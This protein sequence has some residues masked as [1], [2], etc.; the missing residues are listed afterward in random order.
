MGTVRLDEGLDEMIGD[1]VTFDLKRK[2]RCVIRITAVQP[3]RFGDIPKK[4]WRGEWCDSAEHFLEVH[5]K[6]WPKYTLTADFEILAT[7]FELA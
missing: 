1:L 4:L 5:R 7:H 6:C 3:V 2:A